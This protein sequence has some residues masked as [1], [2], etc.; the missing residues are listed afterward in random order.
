MRRAPCHA[1]HPFRPSS[2]PRGAWSRR[3]TFLSPRRHRI[4]MNDRRGPKPKERASRLRAARTPWR[5]PRR[6]AVSS[7]EEQRTTQPPSHT[8]HTRW[9][10]T[11]GKAVSRWRTAYAARAAGCTF[12]VL[13]GGS[14]T[15]TRTGE[16]VATLG[17]GTSSVRS[18]FSEK[19]PNSDSDHKLPG[20]AARHVRC[21]VPTVGSGHPDIASSIR[22]AMKQRLA[23]RR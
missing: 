23:G 17:S 20:N 14:A 4:V 7:A 1:V 10:S 21:G 22:V 9:S 8:A 15:V 12:F 18:Q 6:L 13:T 11:R 16:P 5:L 2:H 3:V 19:A